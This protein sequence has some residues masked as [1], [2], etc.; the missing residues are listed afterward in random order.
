MCDGPAVPSLPNVGGVDKLATYLPS[1]AWPMKSALRVGR[2]SNRWETMRLIRED[3]PQ[4]GVPTTATFKTVSL[5]AGIPFA[6]A[7]PRTHDRNS[8]KKDAHKN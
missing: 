1:D 5:C 8:E 3:F 2:L 6:G 7:E 4:L